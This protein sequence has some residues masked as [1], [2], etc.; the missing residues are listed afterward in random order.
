MRLQQPGRIFRLAGAQLAPQDFS[1]GRQI[2]TSDSDLNASGINANDPAVRLSS[3]FPNYCC[4]DASGFEG[5]SHYS[6]LLECTC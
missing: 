6:R 5:C 2:L 1:R 3:A 4:V